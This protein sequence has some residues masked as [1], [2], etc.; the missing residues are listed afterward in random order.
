MLLQEGVCHRSKLWALI[1]L[2]FLWYFK[3]AINAIHVSLY[4]LC[5][6]LCACV[7]IYVR[8]RHHSR[9]WLQT[10]ALFSAN[11]PKLGAW[12]LTFQSSMSLPLKLP[13]LTI[14]LSTLV[15]SCFDTIVTLIFI[16]PSTI[17]TLAHATPQFIALKLGSKSW[18]SVLEVKALM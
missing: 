2:Y 9:I 17:V 15:L 12:S 8:S 4:F 6:F 14:L 13:C 18:S 5:M 11:T 7:S 1:S 16:A 3:Y 10:L